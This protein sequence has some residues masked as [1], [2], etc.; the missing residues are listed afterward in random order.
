LL[1]MALGHLVEGLWFLIFVGP[2]ILV[3]IGTIIL[4]LRVASL[5]LLPAWWRYWPL[6]VAAIGILGFGIEAWEDVVLHNS[7]PDRGVQTTQLLFSV[8]WLGLSVG[9]WSAARRPSTEP[10]VM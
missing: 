6:V 1:C 3:P 4:G 9:L 5:T 7:T 10:G 2:A 8:L